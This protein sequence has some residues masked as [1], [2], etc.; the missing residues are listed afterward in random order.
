MSTQP[1]DESMP[2]QL[3]IRKM[4]VRDLPQLFCLYV[5]PQA[6]MNRILDRHAMRHRLKEQLRLDQ[7]TYFVAEHG[8]IIA[9]A[10]GLANN[11]RQYKEQAVQLVANFKMLPEQQTG[12]TRNT[13]LEFALLQCALAGHHAMGWRAS[14]D[15]FG[16]RIEYITAKEAP[17]LLPSNQPA[18]KS[19]PE[20]RRPRSAALFLKSLTVR[21]P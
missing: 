21:R 6:Y 3:A 2:K 20:Q 7:Y 9:G 1:E 11:V 4:T 10:F 17:S 15:R 19:Q 5:P 13:L 18:S 8:G 14:R 16:Q 12:N